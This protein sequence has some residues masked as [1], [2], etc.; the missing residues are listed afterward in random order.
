ME[1]I[2]S[3]IWQI[4]GQEIGPHIMILG[5]VH[6]N[7]KTG[8]AVIKNLY[9]IFSEGR[10]KI[11]RGTLTFG[12]GNEEAIQSNERGTNG[13]NLN[14][15]FT[16]TCLSQPAEDFY[17]SRRA[18]DLAP[19]LET[20]DILLDLHATFSKS[21]PFFA[22]AASVN[23]QK[24]FRWFEADIILTDPNFIVGGERA[25]TDEYVEDCGGI[26]ICF[27]AGCME[28]LSLIGSTTESVL[29]V[30]RD[31]HLLFSENKYSPSFRDYKIFELIFRFDLTEEG[32]SYAK[33]IECESFFP[34]VKDQIIGY[35]GPK[36]IIAPNDGVLIFQRLSSQWQIGQPIFFFA[37]KIK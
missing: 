7:E 1:Q 18:H 34:V 9:E 35:C 32:F 2:A 24:I 28:D 22:C 26:G 19:L 12:L 33:N 30:L 11:I 13:S 17:E 37:K 6:G 10:E 4:K 25:T 20:A 36:A 3:N 29:A 31:N 27:E 21:K 16:K 8:V 14:R 23:H 15:L 5:G